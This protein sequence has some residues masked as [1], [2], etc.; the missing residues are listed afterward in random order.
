MG[1]EGK[2]SILSLFAHHG[3]MMYIFIYFYTLYLFLY[4]STNQL[5]IYTC[6]FFFSIPVNL[7]K[8][9]ILTY[10]N[11]ILGVNYAVEAKKN[12]VDAQDRSRKRAISLG[13]LEFFSRRRSCED[14]VT[15]RVFHRYSPTKKSSGWEI[16]T[17]CRITGTF[18]ADMVPHALHATT[19][20]IFQILRI[21]Y[22]T[23]LHETKCTVKFSAIVAKQP[24]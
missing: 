3:D 22:D 17:N 2:K 14:W 5:K 12:H 23:P 9:N 24:R 18:H 1:R 10:P 11:N 13:N 7:L 4:A 6:I 20:S 19:F 15:S 8:I 21:S 16:N